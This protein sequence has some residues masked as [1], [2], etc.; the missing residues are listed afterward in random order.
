MTTAS[1][2][3]TRLFQDIDVRCLGKDKD[4]IDALQISKELFEE[5]QTKPKSIFGS[6]FNLFKKIFSLG[7]VYVTVNSDKQY[8]YKVNARSAEQFLKRHQKIFPNTKCDTMFFRDSIPKL[9]TIIYTQDTKNLMKSHLIRGYRLLMASQEKKHLV[10]ASG[11]NDSVP[12]IDAQDDVILRFMQNIVGE[13]LENHTSFSF[14]TLKTHLENLYEKKSLSTHSSAST[15]PL[16]VKKPKDTPSLTMTEYLSASSRVAT[17]SKDAYLYVFEGIENAFKIM[18]KISHEEKEKEKQIKDYVSQH[19][20]EIV[21]QAKGSGSG[22]VSKSESGL[23]Y[24]LR[25]FYDSKKDEISFHISFGTFDEGGETKI[26]DIFI[27]KK[28]GVYRK[29]QRSPKTD[30]L[31]QSMDKQTKLVQ[32]LST[33]GVPR[34]AM[35]SPNTYIGKGQKIKD[36]PLMERFPTNDLYKTLC[37]KE[38]SSAEKIRMAAQL[39]ET[40]CAMHK[41]GV[42]HLDIKPD[43]ILLDKYGT[44][45]VADFGFAA[46]FKEEINIK[47]SPGYMAPELFIEQT[48]PTANPAQ[49]LWA[50]GALFC[51]ILLINPN[52]DI[53]PFLDLEDRLTKALQSKIYS[54]PSEF[55]QLFRELDSIFLQI[56]DP[57]LQPLIQITK[58]LLETNLN[59]RMTDEQLEAE[60]QPFLPSNVTVQSPRKLGD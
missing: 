1:L 14:D 27:I 43:N 31:R 55:S 53:S 18:K 33:N 21:K 4:G 22:T 52:N 48:S 47:G 50:L 23:P 28:D 3:P 51:D 5:Q 41:N 57:V 15:D 30:A 32:N 25:C 58:K 44:P 35:L 12:K 2:P 7:S 38:F 9:I 49:D 20:E 29:V 26:K 42:I 39:A 40:I 54:N 36:S 17:V 56:T 19:F 34:I 16:S 13:T 11:E 46:K 6:V 8:Y 59:L 37:E 24:T 10:N 45:Y 60:I